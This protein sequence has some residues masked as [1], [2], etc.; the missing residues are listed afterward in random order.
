MGL[1]IF[2]FLGLAE[3]SEREF[4]KQVAQRGPLSD[5]AKFQRRGASFPGRGVSCGRLGRPQAA[6]QASCRLSASYGRLRCL[7]EVSQACRFRREQE[8]REILHCARARDPGW[9]SSQRS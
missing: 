6:S 5:P 7:R 2:V 1:E 8:A 9:Q 4:F 3:L